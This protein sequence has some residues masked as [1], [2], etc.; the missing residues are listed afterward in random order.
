MS[1][2]N[3]EDL[4]YATCLLLV[5]HYRNLAAYEANSG[6]RLGYHTRVITRCCIRKEN[7]A[8]WGSLKK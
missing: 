2:K 4:V 6:E 7:S 8:I 5:K 1:I 3:R